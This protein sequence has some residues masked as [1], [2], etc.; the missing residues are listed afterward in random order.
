LLGTSLKGL[1]A[2]GHATS[3]L[4]RSQQPAYRRQAKACHSPMA[5]QLLSGKAS[6]MT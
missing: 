3:D 4:T 2:D 6:M 1:A 5:S